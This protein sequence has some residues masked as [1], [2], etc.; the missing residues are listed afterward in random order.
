MA[1]GFAGEEHNGR[2]LVLSQMDCRGFG[3]N[4]YAHSL[5]CDSSDDVK[6]TLS[7]R[8]GQIGPLPLPRRQ[9]QTAIRWRQ[10]VRDQVGER[11]S[12]SVG[13]EHATE[14]GL[15]GL[16][17]G[18]GADGE[19]RAVMQGGGTRRDGVPAGQ[20]GRCYSVRGTN[21]LGDDEKDGR[22]DRAKT[23]RGQAAGGLGGAGLRSCD[24]NALQNAA[25]VKEPPVDD[26][27]REAS[28]SYPTS[29]RI[30]TMT[31]DGVPCAWARTSVERYD[32]TG[33]GDRDV[34]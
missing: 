2:Q 31:E 24:Q 30:A 23:E 9:K 7:K 32:E 5:I 8:G 22:D 6:A 16:P 33:S 34:L 19:D 1:G 14:T 29:G 3:Q 4:R 17:G 25:L 26:V 10:R 20:Q 13:V 11:L 28:A 27:W 15:G 12:V 21:L 18:R